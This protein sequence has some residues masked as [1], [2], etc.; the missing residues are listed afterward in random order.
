MKRAMLA[1]SLS[2]LLLHGCGGK[3][4]NPNLPGTVMVGA[5][6][7]VTGSAAD[8]TPEF[9]AA[10]QL[11]VEDENARLAGTSN[12]PRFGLRVQ[13][14][15]STPAGA[16]EATNALAAAGV[17][18]AI[19]PRTSA[20]CAALLP[21]ATTNDIAVLATRSVADDL[22]LPNDALFRLIAPDRQIIPLV[23]ERALSRGL[24]Y[25]CVL[26][27]N[28]P[29]GNNALAILDDALEAAGGDVVYAQAYEPS[30]TPSDVEL[31]TFAD[32][33]I[34]QHALHGAETGVAYFSLSEMVPGFAKL[35]A[36]PDAFRTVGAIAA[37]S[38]ANVPSMVTNDACRLYCQASGLEAVSFALT[39][40]PAVNLPAGENLLN[41]IAARSGKA[42][43]D[44]LAINVYD[45]MRALLR[46]A[47]RTNGTA[48]VNTA[49]ELAGS[50]AGTF[51]PMHFDE[52]GDRVGEFFGVYR[53]EGTEDP[54]WARA[55]TLTR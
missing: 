21:S 28:D 32:A 13:D 30:R 40:Q 22:A 7:D 3:G 10:C 18:Y 45:G 9:T 14:A 38:L 39:S 52:N 36:R 29:F 47:Q 54:R 6:L 49:L 41:R 37:Q 27:R 5:T 31:Q 26:Y 19:G 12:V 16:L 42:N 34:A 51:S 23:A 35:N 17:H 8:F 44:E 50:P 24:K 46:A 20:Q 33:T 25:V 2:V 11:A 48:V 53:I 55:A 4:E 43:P 15:K 1:L